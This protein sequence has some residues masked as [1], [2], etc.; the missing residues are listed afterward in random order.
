M[1]L[2]PKLS[3]LIFI[4]AFCTNAL[5]HAIEV[6]PFIEHVRTSIAELPPKEKAATAAV[7]GFT[8]TRFA[9]KIVKDV[10][11]VV[12]F[13]WLVSEAMELAGVLKDI[14]L[15]SDEEE[16]ALKRYRR[17]GLKKVRDLSRQGRK[18]INMRYDGMT[19][20][21]FVAGAAVAFVV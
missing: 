18:L 13:T 12:G 17:A 14:D 2:R 21:G 20:V 11:K 4:L 10:F 5:C 6:P 3:C 1:I 7:V 9:L 19:K 15:I 8:T 16:A